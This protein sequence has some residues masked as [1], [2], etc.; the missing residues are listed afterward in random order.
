M[1]KRIERIRCAMVLLSALAVALTGCGGN[2]ASEPGWH[3]HNLDRPATGG[4]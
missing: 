1:R 3:D 4:P 2:A